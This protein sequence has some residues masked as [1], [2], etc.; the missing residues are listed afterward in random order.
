MKAP[1]M[2]SAPR[3]DDFYVGYL[4]TPLRAIRA[5]A[6]LAVAL[7]LA[8][9]GAALL[10]YRLQRDPAQGRWNEAGEVAITGTLI[11]RPYPIVEVAGAAGERPRVVLLVSEGKA[12]APP[13][14]A[15]LD[16]KPVTVHGY[17]I[18]RD[19]LT[20]LQLSRDPV[21]AE[22][23]A[24]PLAPRAVGPRTLTG[25]IV[26]AKCYLGAMNPG[27]GKVHKDCASLC[28]LGG[29]PPLFVTRDTAGKTHYRLLADAQG[30]PIAEAAAARAGEFITLSGTLLELGGIELFAVDPAALR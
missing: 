24:L 6:W 20:V 27:E 10:L 2:P 26:D 13:G 9:D 16:G 28:L 23:A 5:A 17:E 3:P 30:G 8:A 4:R 25:E 18:L 14:A 29:I 1:P 11:A 19:E 21:A 22:A 15:A 7:V 12:G